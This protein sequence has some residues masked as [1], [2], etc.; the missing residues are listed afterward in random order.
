[1]EH[2]YF[3]SPVFPQVYSLLNKHDF[4]NNFECFI[5]DFNPVHSKS[6][7]VVSTQAFAINGVVLSIKSFWEY[8]SESPRL[9]TKMMT[10][11]Y[12]VQLHTKDGAGKFF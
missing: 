9:A 5:K 10:E 2:S 6:C 8:I 11:S 12:P 3:N 1:M 7:R 4:V